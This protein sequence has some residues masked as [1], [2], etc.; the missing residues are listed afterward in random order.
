MQL[1]LPPE[2][3]MVPI[4]HGYSLQ[5]SLGSGSFGHVVKAKCLKT[6]REVAIKLIQNICE[7]EYNCVKIIREI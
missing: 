3:W 4:Q 7:H 6:G 1:S 2:I 5:S